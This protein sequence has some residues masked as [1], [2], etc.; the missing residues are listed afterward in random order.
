MSL[1]DWTI[2]TPILENFRWWR[3][4]TT[5]YWLWRTSWPGCRTCYKDSKL[6]HAAP[7]CK[8]CPMRE[9]GPK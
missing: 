4:L 6:G 1:D 2:R 7:L 8:T 3:W 5:R 9:W